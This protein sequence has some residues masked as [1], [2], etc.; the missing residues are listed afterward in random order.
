VW[1]PLRGSSHAAGTR[2]GD[3]R[4]RPRERADVLVRADRGRDG[5]L[6][7][8]PLRFWRRPPPPCA[9]ETVGCCRSRFW[10]RH[11]PWGPQSDTAYDQSPPL[12]LVSGGTRSYVCRR[13]C[14]TIRAFA[15]T[16]DI[17]PG[18]AGARTSAFSPCGALAR[19][20]IR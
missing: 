4:R 10:R 6:R 17:C 7:S 15:C 16:R 3:Q 19:R 5:A 20:P 1:V 9:G 18:Q 8:P 13:R 12:H 2:G 11:V 14:T